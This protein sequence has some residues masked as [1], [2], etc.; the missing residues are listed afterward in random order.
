VLRCFVDA[1]HAGDKLSRRS[2]TVFIIFLQ[3]GPLIVWHSKRQATI[4]T[5]YFGSEFVVAASCDGNDPRTALQVA[6]VLP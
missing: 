1:D 5:E 6:N 2:R 3:M 4:E